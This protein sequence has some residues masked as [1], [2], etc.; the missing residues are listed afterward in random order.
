VSAARRALLIGL[1]AA[2]AHLVL[3]VVLP[4]LVAFFVL[5]AAAT[6]AAAVALARVL[7]AADRADGGD[8]GA[9]HRIDP[10]PPRPD[11][12]DEPAWWPEFEAAFRA[13]ADRRRSRA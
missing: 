1:G 2:G 7:G 8:G 6:L 12:G 4:A 13:H 9:G 11:P 5:C 10:R 3:A